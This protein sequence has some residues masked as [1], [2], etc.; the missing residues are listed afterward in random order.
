MLPSMGARGGVARRWASPPRPCSTPPLLQAPGELEPP[1]PP[2]PPW[3]MWRRGT[4]AP[5]MAMADLEP[6]APPP[7]PPWEARPPRRPSRRRPRLC[8]PRAGLVPARAR[9]ATERCCRPQ[10]TS[11]LPSE[12]AE[13]GFGRRRREQRRCRLGRKGRARVGGDWERR[14]REWR[15]RGKEIV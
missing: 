5:A 1:S 6:L 9:S 14:E 4:T 12:G 13:E 15:E 3:A 8:R 11:P 7:L 10:L 2:G